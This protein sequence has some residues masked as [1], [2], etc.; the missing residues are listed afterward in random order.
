MSTDTIEAPPSANGEH[1]PTVEALDVL[2]VRYSV[3]D[4]ALA[5]LAEQAKLHEF[6]QQGS[7]KYNAA[8]SFVYGIS[9]TKAQLNRERLKQTE[10]ARDFT[11]R[12]NTEAKRIEARLDAIA[13]P[14]VA[15]RKAID[16]E[17]AR[18]E[19]EK[20]EA[21]EQAR[22]AEEKRKRD[23][24]EAKQ[25]A[26]RDAEEKRLA[27]ERAKL[28]AERQELEAKQR[29]I[30]EANRKRE[31][32]ARIKREAEEAEARKKQEAIDAENRRKEQ[33]LQAERDR[34]AEVERQQR[35]QLE[36]E[37]AE[38]EQKQ[39][40]AQEKIDAERRKVEAEKARLEQERLDRE[41]AERERKE[42]EERAE[43]ERIE[44]EAKAK[45]EQEEA[46][47]RAKLVESMRPD[48][49]KIN[50]FGVSV[51]EWLQANRPAVTDPVAERFVKY[52]CEQIDI[53][54][55]A[56][57]KRTAEDAAGDSEIPF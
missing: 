8:V 44:A 45:R 21:A 18:I 49:E 54:A 9:K 14:L 55:E 56:C 6:D 20:A 35:E 57:I 32:E 10:Q 38:A 25:K 53:H 31:E 19:R 33:E 34:L 16:D 42:A 43:R 3:T 37:R 15:Q 1:Q 7:P 2:P 11:A 41:R 36:R 5:E 51:R 24:E 48:V 39:R 47:A 17:A 22:L 27:E 30:D 52:V 29:E 13:A 26:I 46:E 23:E 40:E 12:V 4:H 50:R 28:E